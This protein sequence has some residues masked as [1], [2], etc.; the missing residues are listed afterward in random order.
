MS[1]TLKTTVTEL[2]E[3]RVR[4]EVEVPSSEIEDRLARKA[5]QLGREMKLPGFRRGKVPAPLVIQR[6]GREVVLE[7]AVADNRER[8]TVRQRTFLQARISY[9]GRGRIM[10]VQQPAWG[11]QLFDRFKPL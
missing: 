8:A 6:V 11:Q 2:P 4:V 3:S 10:E 1:A 7:E 5:R 9:G